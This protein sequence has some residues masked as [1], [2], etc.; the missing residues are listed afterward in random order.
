MSL[1]I[2]KIMKDGFYGVLYLKEYLGASSG[3]NKIRIEG[4]IKVL[5]TKALG[6][7]PGNGH[8]D[9]VYHISGPTEEL[10]LNGCE[11]KAVY[12]TSDKYT[13]RECWVLK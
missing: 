1:E 6:I 3:E 12:S 4:D 8:A 13:H 5:G 2:K 7:V 10:F 11:V 9:Y